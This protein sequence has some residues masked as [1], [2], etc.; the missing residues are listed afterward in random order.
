MT[1]VSYSPDATNYGELMAQADARVKTALDS[2]DPS[3][4]GVLLIS[5]QDVAGFME[6]AAGETWLSKVRWYGCDGN[7]LKSTLI[8]NRTAAGFATAVQFKAPIMGIG[9]AGSVPAAARQIMDDVADITG[10]YPDFYCVNSYDA[11]Q[12]LSQAYNIVRSYDAQLIKEILPS[13]CESYNYAG[14]PRRL[15][16]AGDLESA[17]YIFYSVFI[18]Q[19]GYYWD[20][21]ATYLSEGDFILMK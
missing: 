4:V 19:S 13:V 15:N 3:E 14:I 5:L 2:Y 21:C 11:V 6:A 8:N 10:T 1:G 12:I 16:E 18:R 7:V 9:T 17:N 20:S